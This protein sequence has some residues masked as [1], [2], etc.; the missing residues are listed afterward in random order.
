M[1]NLAVFMIA[2][3]VCSGPA[4]ASL[5]GH[6]NAYDDGSKAWSGTTAFSDGSNLT[7]YVEWAVFGP[8]DFPYAGYTPTA[9]E[10]TYACQVFSTGT[11]AIVSYATAVNNPANSA[12][13]F[14]D[15]A[16]DAVKNPPGPSLTIPGSISWPFDGL[17]SGENSVGLAFSSLMVPED[18]YG[19]VLNGGSYAV[20]I[21]VPT[22]SATE[23][24]EPATL[25]LLV[26][27]GMALLRRR[28]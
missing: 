19:L 2:V 24:P 8:G 26:L 20:V 28:R 3:L 18:L 6:A 27:G 5:D 15:L 22:P 1:R 12:G 21:P 16:G 4:W 13:S 9:G 10:L 25:G 7:G 14:A 11:D 23:I 17:G